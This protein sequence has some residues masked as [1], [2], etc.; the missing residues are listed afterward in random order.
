MLLYTKILCFKD[1]TALMVNFI[2]RYLM[3]SLIFS[4]MVYFFAYQK[5]IHFSYSFDFFMLAIVYVYALN[6]WLKFFNLQ[7][8]PNLRYFLILLVCVSGL[9]SQACLTYLFQ[10]VLLVVC[11]D[12]I[13]IQPSWS[14][15][16]GLLLLSVAVKTYQSF[17]LCQWEQVLTLIQFGQAGLLKGDV[18]TYLHILLA[19]VLFPVWL[20]YFF[21]A[22]HEIFTHF[23]KISAP[24]MEAL[25]VLLSAAVMCYIT[26]VYDFLVTLTVLYRQLSP[27]LIFSGFALGGIVYCYYQLLQKLVPI[28]LFISGVLAM[29]AEYQLFNDAYHRLQHLNSVDYFQLDYKNPADVDFQKIAKPRNLVLI[30]VESLESS[31]QNKKLFEHDLL[32]HLNKLDLPKVSFNHFSQLPNTGWTMAGIIASQCGVPYKLSTAYLGNMLGQ[33]LKTFMPHAWCLGDVLNAYG[34]RNVFLN[35][36]S[37][38]FAGQG[39]FFKTHHYDEI[40][41]RSEWQH[42]GY[43]SA[44]LQFWGLA[45]DFLFTEAKHTLN[46]LMQEEKPFNLTILTIDTHGID[47]RLSKTCLQ[48]GGRTFE[49]IVECS[50]AEVANFIHYV[51]DKGWLDRVTIVVTGDHLVMKNAISDK[52]NQAQEHF[53]Y[54]AFIADKPLNKSRD[55][56]VHFDLYPS[57]LHALGFSWDDDRLGLGHSALGATNPSLNPEKRLTDLKKTILSESM[58]Y[59]KLW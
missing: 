24:V 38:E 3:Y 29:D 43:S 49:N 42:K 21:K 34:Y 22:Q 5:L 30:Y 59:K 25:Q 40:Y 8:K 45:D 53:I 6:I 20:L 54:N 58:A 19:A 44:D 16:F 33:H 1:E 10:I 2:N 31:Y 17:G 56:I 7:L 46:R 18:E 26:G 39:L 36:S 14:N 57:I 47:G 52:L 51:A 13:K 15:F 50:S 55:S 12:K 35:G 4:M 9:L 28:G 32:R 23:C 37:L 41:G 48:Q 27:M 11:I